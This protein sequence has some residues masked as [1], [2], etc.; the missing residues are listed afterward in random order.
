MKLGDIYRSGMI[1]IR[2]DGSCVE[3]PLT[4]IRKPSDKKSFSK[5]RNGK[6]IVIAS[7]Y[8]W[9]DFSGT[10]PENCIRFFHSF[11][12]DL[13]WCKIPQASLS[14][15]D[16]IDKT[17]CGGVKAGRERAGVIMVTLDHDSGMRTK[18]F[19]MTA[20]VSE[21]CK[22][23]G[24]PLTVVEYG[25]GGGWSDSLE[26]VRK[27]LKSKDVHIIRN[28][29]DNDQKKMAEFFRSHKLFICPSIYDAS[30]KTIA[31][32]LCRGTRVMLGEHCIGGKKYINSNTGSIFK[33]PTCAEEMWD[34]FKNVVDELSE[35]MSSEMKHASNPEQ[36]SYYYHKH[37]GLEKT[38][39]FLAKE[40]KENFPEYR[41]I[42]YPEFK[43][44]LLKI[45]RL[46][47]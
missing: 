2:N 17:W 4:V 44:H 8:K 31:E 21:A 16:M 38:S 10:L 32:S 43:K 23:T 33:M 1:G 34:N 26:K 37:W 41:A 3:L 27:F 22:N 14:E 42:C 46:N 45:L 12:N 47:E 25:R 36:V 15:S 39:V 20:A 24:Y 18:G 5:I 7:H 35:S 6:S 28:K 9:V 13:S 40:I 19:F 30:P 11:N 29:P